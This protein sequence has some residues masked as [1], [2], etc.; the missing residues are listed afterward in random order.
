MSAA[1]LLLGLL[2]GAG[3]LLVFIGI[4]TLANKALDDAGRK[5]GFWP[6]NAGLILIAASVYLFSSAG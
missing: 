3:S 1:P 5:R 2:L 4:R 6:L